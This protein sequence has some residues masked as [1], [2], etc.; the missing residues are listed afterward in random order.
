MRGY[1]TYVKLV[2]M[3][4]A[5]VFANAN[6]MRRGIHM[7][8]KGSTIIFCSDD[9]YYEKERRGLKKNTVR[10]MDKEEVEMFDKNRTNLTQI[11]IIRVGHHEA[12]VRQLSDITVWQGLYIFSWR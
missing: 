3:N 2:I 12:F 6:A 7:E 4:I 10:R 5:V 1:L 8:I 11:Q 9:E